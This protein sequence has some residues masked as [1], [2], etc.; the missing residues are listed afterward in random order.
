[1]NEDSTGI[2]LLALFFMLCCERTTLGFSGLSP[3]K[4]AA[5]AALLF[6][7][8]LRTREE[9]APRAI[10][11]KVSFFCSLMNERNTFELADEFGEIRLTI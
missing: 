7:P 6:A 11:S 9:V 5:T 3:R 10:D 2:T 8:S 4:S 1:V